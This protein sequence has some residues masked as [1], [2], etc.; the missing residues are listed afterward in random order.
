MVDR[1]RRRFIAGAGAAAFG[2]AG[3]L[4]TGIGG[5][6]GSPDRTAYAG[7]YHW[8]F[9]LLDEAGE[10]H[11]QLVVEAGTRL[12][13]VAVNT[14]AHEA[15]DALPGPV[16]TALPGHGALEERNAERIPA[17]PSGDLHDALEAANERYPDHS[18]AVRA[19]G[20]DHMPGG[21]MGG[22]MDGGM[23]LPS[24][25]LP[26]EAS[27]PAEVDL[28]ADERGEYTLDCLIYCGYGHPYME[29]EGGFVVE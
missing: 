23:M 24:V 21:G 14:E 8:G 5:S 22:G 27:R 26:H 3:C 17:P 20:A 9:V 29:L 11:E 12:R 19:A 6:G 25:P 10:E 7:A 4:G 28:V 16:R 1:T 18:V 2:L 13:L 15:V